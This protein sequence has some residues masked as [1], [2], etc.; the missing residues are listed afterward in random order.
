MTVTVTATATSRTSGLRLSGNRT[1]EHGNRR[2]PGT[3]ADPA[4]SPAHAGS[5]GLIPASG[6][7]ASGAEDGDPPPSCTRVPVARGEAELGRA[8][9]AV[10][11]GDRR[12]ARRLLLDALRAL[13]DDDG[14]AA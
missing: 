5:S 7:D 10:R 4:P 12:A 8:L 6:D 13:E 3:S 9:E 14:G 11:T 1:A 2:R